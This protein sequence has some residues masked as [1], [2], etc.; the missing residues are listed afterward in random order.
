MQSTKL[1]QDD[2]II[3]DR[4][5]AAALARFR[6][7]GYNKT[8][9]AEIA[10]DSGM[11]TAN[12]Y[13]YFE[14]KQEMACLCVGNCIRDR[15]E[16]VET[17]S[18][19]VQLNARDRLRAFVQTLLQNCH[20]TYSR[21]VK[22]HELVM[23]ITNEHPDIIH[24]KIARLQAQIEKILTSG[25]TAGEFNITDIPTTARAIYSSIAIFD[26][27]FSINFYS[28]EE[29]QKRANEVVDLILDGLAIIH[30]NQ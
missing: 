21:D 23:V 20:D 11:S 3:R 29:F 19:N 28:L 27:P 12:I 9:M 4:I 30:P 14:N 22:I 5:M 17:A 15:I 8:T 16:Q 25:N 13:R 6:H 7:Y 10:A 1:M 18:N 26:I 2:H 24:N